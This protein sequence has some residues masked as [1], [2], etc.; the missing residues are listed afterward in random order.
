MYCALHQHRASL[1]A[2]KGRGDR[3]WTEDIHGQ[4][5]KYLVDGLLSLTTHNGV[6][7]LI[8]YELSEADSPR[9]YVELAIPAPVMHSIVETITSMLNGAAPPLKAP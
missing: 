5:P 7:R 4:C 2:V 8:F 1:L 9:P 6:H 3:N